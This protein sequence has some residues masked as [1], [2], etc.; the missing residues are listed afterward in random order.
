MW[1]IFEVVCLEVDKSKDKAKKD[2]LQFIHQSN[3]SYDGSSGLQTPENSPGYH[4][5]NWENLGIIILTEL[6]IN[7]HLTV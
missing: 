3:K 4:Q 1:T 7:L 2:K 6:S 5:K